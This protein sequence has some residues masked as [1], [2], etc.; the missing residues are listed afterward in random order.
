MDC[1]RP[2]ARLP[3]TQVTAGSGRAELSQFTHPY[4]WV[5]LVICFLI[6]SAAYI[7]RIAWSPAATFIG[8]DLGIRS[9]LLGWFVTAFFAGY[10]VANAAGGFVVDR[11][12]AKGVIC[13]GL[14]PLSA[15]V[16]G[17]GLIRTVDMGLAVQLGMGLTAGVNF[18]ST[19]K[20]I[21]VWFGPRERGIA[22]GILTAATSTS[23]I[24]ANLLFP[25]II[26][27][28]SWPVLYYLLGACV[29]AVWLLS[30]ALLREAPGNAVRRTLASEPI[31]KTLASLIRDRDFVV[32]ALAWFGGLWGTWGVTFWGNALM[33]KGRGLG[34]VEAGHVFALFGLGGLIAKPLYGSIS[35]RLPFRRK[36]MLLPCLIGFV[37]LLV[38]FAWVRGSRN[39]V[40]L[41]PVLGAFAF[42]YTPLMNALLTEVVGKRSV[43]SAAGLMNAFTQS[44]TIVAPVIVGFIFQLTSS[45]KAAFLALALGPLLSVVCIL[46]MREADR[47]PRDPA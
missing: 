46:M 2:L 18:S 24:L 12:G 7:V 10:V 35:D 40:M 5:V 6:M 42:G 36:T 25:A 17:F 30:M 34:S 13:T 47:A 28:Y 9:A 39:F 15:L 3:V 8:D 37:V 45:F 29:V 22:F 38:L 1:V 27:R 14:V 41:A 33:V 11:F 31:A 44:S 19:T 20:L 4:R 43:G 26:D 23:L 32:L 21:S 16:A